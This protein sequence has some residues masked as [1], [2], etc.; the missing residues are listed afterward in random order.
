MTRGPYLQ[1]S[2]PFVAGACLRDLVEEG[3]LDL[4]FRTLD[5]KDV[6]PLDRP[7]HLHQELAI[8][9]AVAGQRNLVVATGT[10]SGKTECFLVPIIDALL[11]ERAAGTL[12]EPGVRALLLY[13]MNALA[14]DQLRRLRRILQPVPEIT[15]GRYV[16]DTAQRS[17]EALDNFR[18]RFPR[19]PRFANELLSREEMQAAPPRILLTNYAMLEYLLLRPADSSIFDGESGRHWR[20]IALDEAH[21]YDGAAGSEIAMLLRRVRDRVVGSERGRLQCFA[22]SATLGRG[23]EDYPSLIEYALA[24]FD[25]RFEWDPSDPAR[26][27]VVS[28]S[29][30]PLASAQPAYTLPAATYAKLNAA[31][32]TDGSAAAIRRVLVEESPDAAAGVDGSGSAEDVLGA[33]L[34]RDANVLAVQDLL[35]LGSSEFSAVGR[36]VF[37]PDWRADDLVELVECAVNAR[38]SENDTPLLPAK[39]HFLLRSLEGAYLCLSPD[40]PANEPD[41]LLARHE[42][43]PACLNAGRH[44]AMFELGTCRR[45]GAEYLLGVQRGER[46]VQAPPFSTLT[47]L[48]LGKPATADDEDEAQPDESADNVPTDRFICPFCGR[49]SA[50]GSDQCAC[51]QNVTGAP[52]IATTLARASQTGSVLRRCPACAAR[53]GGE[54]VSRFLPGADAP[55]SVIATGIYQELPPSSDAQMA[56]A[57]GEGRKLLV[58]ADSRQD[59]AFFSPYFERTYQRAIQRSLVLDIAARA[60]VDEPYRFDD[61]VLPMMRRAEGSLVLDPDGSRATNQAAVRSWLLQ[62]VVA[63]DRRQSLEGTGLVEIAVALPRRF[64]A[65]RALTELGLSDQEAEDLLR[66]LLDTLKNGAAVTIPEGVDVRDEAF[67]PRNREYGVRG[68]TST[69]DVIAWRPGRGSNRRLDIVAK[70]LRQIGSAT[71]PTALLA[72]IW[73]YLS[74]PSGIWTT[75]LVAYSDKKNGALW[76]IAT[77]RLD[78]VPMSDRHL[79]LRCDRCRQIWW[80][81]VRGVCSTYGCEGTLRRVEAPS[82]LVE[83]HYAALY[84]R[85]AP[86]GMK[87]EE[88]TAQ[89]TQAAGSAIQDAFMR[90]D[91]N[92]LSCST[93]FELGVD[94]GEVES[95]LLRNMPPSPANYVQR[96]GRAGRRLSSAALVVTYAQ[97]RNH[98][99]AYFA[100]P[101]LMIEGVIQP[102]RVRVDNPT[103]VRRHTHAVAFSAFER[104]IGE[105]PDVGSFFVGLAEEPAADDRF[106]AWL[107]TK[108]ESLG[109]AIRRIVPPQTVDVL[110]LDDWAWVEALVEE[111]EEDPTRGWLRRASAEVRSDLDELGERIAEAVA[112]ERFDSAGSYKRQRTTML[113]THLLSFLARKNVLPKYGF[114]V[115][116]IPLDLGRSGDAD[117]ARLQLDRDLKM[118]ISEYAPGSEIVAAKALWRSEGLRVQPGREWPKRVLAVCKR[119]GAVREGLTEVR[120]DCGVCHSTERDAFHSGDFVIPVFGFLGSRSSNKPGDSRPGRGSSPVSYFS[121]YQD[122]EPDLTVIPELSH[123]GQLTQIRSSRQGRITVINRG[124]ASRGYQVCYRCG[125]GA[126]APVVGEGGGRRKTTGHRDIR[127]P[128]SKECTNWLKTVFL[129][130]EYLTD[131]VEIRT[132]IQ[133]SDEDARSTL[134]AL[135][136]GAATLSIKREELDGTLYTYGFGEPSAFVVFDTV[137]GGA[138]HAQRVGR[139]LEAVVHAGLQRVEACSC[140]PETACYQCLRS[141]SNQTWHESLSRGAAISV[142]SR[143]VGPVS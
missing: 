56:D 10:G 95:V 78:F 7:L 66:L 138:G 19:E 68:E 43:C 45:C 47:Y 71:D 130:H 29:R 87:V 30:R 109:A 99:L 80:R 91:I 97:R 18:Q 65:P 64:A 120:P 73:D 14:N 118:A 82:E 51:E 126:P 33:V 83:N 112:D 3:V 11:R 101:K 123:G 46:L 128:G 61:L 21:V 27:D 139:Q 39:Y 140:G 93:T 28:A 105:H 117:A 135:L 98:D 55:V 106:V 1:A 79:P 113:R 8:R 63:A 67:A 9:K 94:V 75:T 143:L 86:I 48:L 90:G 137:P 41:L 20:T 23:I 15:F 92:V 42:E 24:I 119:C 122:R 133:M 69:G 35:E 72:A 96:A 111:S 100:D 110:G 12:D 4:G 13:P 40:H 88:H 108:P 54:I 58:F 2:A 26:Q 125:Y 134:Y 81:S 129:G 142:L 60:P 31:R 38:H 62:E 114:P 25:E 141:Y 57:V 44:V 5:Q 53:T 132:S 50:S 6:F 17:K 77:D 89:W 22:T 104:E 16:G 127:R 115:D 136:E 116:V 85:L 59:A 103:I 84:R 52:R 36:S 70:I 34:S 121:E 124:P 76:R 102:P 32:L 74:D 49:M 37:G 107:K 131:V